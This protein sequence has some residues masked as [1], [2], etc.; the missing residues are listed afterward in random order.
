MALSREEGDDG[1]TLA[2][3]KKV[4]DIFTEIKIGGK[5]NWNPVQ[6]GVVLATTTILDLRSLY[7][8][9]GFDFLLSSRL[10]QDSLENVFSCIRMKNPIPTPREFKKALRTSRST[11]YENDDCVHLLNYMHLRSEDSVSG[12]LPFSSVNDED[13][14]EM[15]ELG[16]DEA[17]SL[18]YLTGRTDSLDNDRMVKRKSVS[19]ADSSSTLLAPSSLISEDLYTQSFPAP[20]VSPLGSDCVRPSPASKEVLTSEDLNRDDGF[21]TVVSRKRQQRSNSIV[22]KSSQ[23][24]NGVSGVPRRATIYVGCISLETSSK[25]IKH[26]LAGKYSDHEFSCE[27]FRSNKFHRSFKVNIPLS[28]RDE[29]LDS[30][31]W[32]NNVVVGKFFPPKAPTQSFPNSF[33][34]TPKV[35][36]TTSDQSTNGIGSPITESATTEQQLSEFPGASAGV[37]SV[38]QP[39]LAST[40]IST[41]SSNGVNK[42]KQIAPPLP[43][44]PLDSAMQ[45]SPGEEGTS[46]STREQPTEEPF[47]R[48]GS[49]QR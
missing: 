45:Q 38:I 23:P 6:R 14:V 25:D 18:F 26:F 21:R 40:R 32:P 9:K 13:E 7:S 3:L 12:D 28:L 49:R 5:G 15:E 43:A 39:N 41:R 17:N 48:S 16:D 36:E 37:S 1:E 20:T 24:V 2:F 19:F 34:N 4:R 42:P 22:G 47:S 31:L 44:Q 46:R 30:A 27:D 29:L 35:H 10:T 11:S 8:A 33:L